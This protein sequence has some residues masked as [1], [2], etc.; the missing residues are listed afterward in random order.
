[1]LILIRVRVRF[2]SILQFFGLYHCS[3]KTLEIAKQ[4]TR[5]LARWH[6]VRVLI[7]PDGRRLI[8]KSKFPITKSR[9]VLRIHR[10]V[11]S[12]SDSKVV[13]SNVDNYS[14]LFRSLLRLSKHSILSS[15][16]RNRSFCHSTT[17]HYRKAVRIALKRKGNR[18]QY[19]MQPPTYLQC[20]FLFDP[21]V[22]V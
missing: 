7:V 6:T 8:L 15:P 9:Q 11:D 4:Y 13:D 5:V 2:A 16:P 22:G 19:S 18:S 1:V 21:L 14:Y 10:D 17:Q 20:I 12:A 3:L